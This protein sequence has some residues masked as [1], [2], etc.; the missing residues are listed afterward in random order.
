MT[1][2]ATSAALV[3]RASPVALAEARATIAVHSKSFSLASRLLP[4]RVRDDAVV[5][6]AWCRHADDAVDHA[7]PGTAPAAL[8]SLER[9]LARV[10]G[11]AEPDDTLEAALRG[12]VAA[13]SIPRRYP[14]E[15]LA[16]M[17]MDVADT[18]YLRFEELDLYCHRVAG[19]VGLMMAHVMGVADPAALRNAAHLGMAMQ[20][21]NIA[22][23]VHED[24][25][26]GRLYLPDALLA[27]HGAAGLAAELG[28]AFPEAARSPVA[29][30][31]RELLERAEAL[32]RSGD[33]GLIALAPRSA[34]AVR[35]ARLIYSA[36]GD[37]V[38]RQRCDPLAGRAHVSGWGK[39]R[40]VARAA[41][42]TAAE[43]PRRTARPH[44][45]APIE[46]EL[47]FDELL[48]AL[49]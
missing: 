9:G 44:R 47:T 18:R 1:P 34:L 23:D 8:A 11:G 7:P 12:V 27:R 30:A 17:A 5:L 21:T 42:L 15:L 20:L 46:T 3:V 28:G 4:A 49:P 6:Y 29:S 19:V 48:R 35:A 22:R 13:R 43:L 45:A 26:R 33:D 16:G 25:R 14:A 36:I 40:L 37:Q 24:W 41:A 39:L 10:Y 2:P 38:R 32:Y 31:T